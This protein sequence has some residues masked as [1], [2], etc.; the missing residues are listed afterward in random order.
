M[1]QNYSVNIQVPPKQMAELVVELHTRKLRFSVADAP[2]TSTTAAQPVPQA[3]PPR[4][5]TS[6]AHGVRNKGISARDLI[7][8][9][10]REKQPRSAGE[11]ME[12]FISRRFSPSTAIP[13]L[14]KELKKGR[15][16]RI[17][18]DAYALPGFNAVEYYNAQGVPS[19][20]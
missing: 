20:G 14:S 5:E 11:F 4:R 3:P 7:H 18:A 2:P 6:Y 16:V 1:D 9:T 17:G 8:E 19:Q 12:V 10:L 13:S 15:V